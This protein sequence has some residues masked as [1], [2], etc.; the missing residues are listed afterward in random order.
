MVI[1]GLVVVAPCRLLLAH[2]RPSPDNA[3]TYPVQVFT[4]GSRAFPAKM[5]E[6]RA[7]ALTRPI[8]LINGFKF[9]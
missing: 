6:R 7:K 3:N 2:R 5:P 8:A 9:S 1:A 4:F